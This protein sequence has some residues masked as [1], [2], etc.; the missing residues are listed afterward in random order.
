MLTALMHSG[1][2]HV[3]VR[4]EVVFCGRRA[5]QYYTASREEPLF[6]TCSNIFT[7]TFLRIKAKLRPEYLWSA[8]QSIH[9]KLPTCVTTSRQQV[10]D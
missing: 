8:L 4:A 6:T 9:A 5:K 7:V 10:W 3:V 2:Y 1:R